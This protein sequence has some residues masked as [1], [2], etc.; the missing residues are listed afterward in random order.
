MPNK[1]RLT[2]ANV[3]STVA[4]FLALS[5]GVAFA[6][7]RIQ[8]GDIADN[9]VKSAKIAPGAVRTGNLFKRAITSGKLALGAVHSDQIADKVVGSQQIANGAVGSQ[10][11]AN[12]SV[13]SQQIGVAAVA[14]ANLQFPVFAA[15]SPLGGPASVPAGEPEAYPLSDSSW[16]QKPGQ[17]DVV[18]GAVTATLAYDGNGGG[19]CRVF[20]E[21]SLNGQPVGGGEVSTDSTTPEQIERS[22]GAQP[23]ID[24]P[25]PR[26]NRLTTRIGSQDCTPDSTID[27]T[28]FRV[29]DF[30]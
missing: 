17:I 11:I 25:A 14:P 9:A 3:V 16:E 10:Q 21:V 26:T 15:A 28:R 19:S 12:D 6:A 29:L 27:S 5:G 2:Y 1:P 18:F 20:I 22:V 30:G 7:S 13:G 24:P 8:T 4:L 23:E